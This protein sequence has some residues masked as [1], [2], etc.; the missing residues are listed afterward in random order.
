[1]NI[2]IKL[3]QKNVIKILKFG[4]YITIIKLLLLKYLSFFI[5]PQLLLNN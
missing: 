3:F 5:A 1:M 2:N 4:Q